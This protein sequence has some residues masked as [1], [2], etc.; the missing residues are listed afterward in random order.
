MFLGKVL[1]W[2]PPATLALF[3]EGSISLGPFLST[4]KEL[5]FKSHID[6]GNW[7]AFQGHSWE[8][9]FMQNEKIK[10]CWYLFKT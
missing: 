7:I 4:Q 1:F 3:S 6:I 8:I 2:A 10:L 9:F 5:C